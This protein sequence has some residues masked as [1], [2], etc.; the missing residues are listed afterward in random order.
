MSLENCQR[1]GQPS[2]PA[3]QQI[4]DQIHSICDDIIHFC[5]QPTEVTFYHAEQLLQSHI[6]SLAC[7]FFQLFLMS[8]HNQFDYTSWLEKGTYYKGELV[9]RTLKT[10]YGEVRYWVVYLYR[11][12]NSVAR[13]SGTMPPYHDRVRGTLPWYRTC[14]STSWCCWD[15]CGSASCCIM[16]GQTSMPEG[17]RGHPSLCRRA[18]APAPRSRFLASPA[19]PPVPP[20]SRPTR[21]HPSRPVARHPASCPRGDGRARWIPRSISVPVPPV[22]MVAGATWAISRPTVIPAVDCGAS[23]IARAAGAIAKKPTARRC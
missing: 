6:S 9:S 18:C 14:F 12:G 23:C 4:Q 19:S 7:L 1:S 15:S 10:L 13:K 20:V 3:L 11:A 17:I 16:P 5:I 8:V 22:R 2:P 21:T